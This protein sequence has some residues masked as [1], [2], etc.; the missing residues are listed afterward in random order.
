[1]TVDRSHS[2]SCL[3]RSVRLWSEPLDEIEQAREFIHSGATFIGVDLD[4]GTP[5]NA[6]RL[7]PLV[8]AGD[9]LTPLPFV[10]LRNYEAA[11]EYFPVRYRW[12]DELRVGP[13][14]LPGM[15]E[16]ELV[17]SNP[18][19]ILFYNHPGS[20]ERHESESYRNLLVSYRLVLTSKPTAV[21]RLYERVV[22]TD[23]LRQG[24]ASR[25]R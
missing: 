8:H 25:G 22:S 9:I 12:V 17:A 24:V 5:D 3:R 1:M 11:T 13:P 2:A 15:S 14:Q 23:E 21:A 20:R 16:K 18:A 19:F 6:P 10:D 4:A 7:N